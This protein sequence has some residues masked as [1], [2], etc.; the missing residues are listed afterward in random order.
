VKRDPTQVAAGLRLLATLIEE[1]GLP[2]AGGYPSL[3]YTFYSGKDEDGTPVLS[4]LQRAARAFDAAGVEYSAYIDADNDLPLRA[5]LPGGVHV[6][7]RVRAAEVCE[8]VARVE[9][10][11]TYEV[12]DTLLPASRV[13]QDDAT[14]DAA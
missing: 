3:H 14:R 2:V 8:P 10:I 7:Y 4:V 5:T 1:H 6:Q 11:V 9:E 12:P 13:E